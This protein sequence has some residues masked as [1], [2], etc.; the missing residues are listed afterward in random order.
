MNLTKIIKKPLLTEKT[1]A[2]S[3]K[4][5]HVFKV[6]KMATKIEIKNAVEYYFKVKVESV[7]TLVGRN[8][9]KKTAKGIIPAKYYKKAM[10]KLKQ[11][12]KIAL[13]EGV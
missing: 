9:P 1:T 7:N 13:F 4:S 8:K 10:V 12:E 3:S 5:I 6:N 11:G 2:L